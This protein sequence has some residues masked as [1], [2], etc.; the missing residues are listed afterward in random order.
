MDVRSYGIKVRC[1]LVSC[2]IRYFTLCTEVNPRKRM[3]GIHL[4][5]SNLISMMG[6]STL[7]ST[8]RN[9]SRR[10]QRHP[11]K[12]TLHPTI[13]LQHPPPHSKTIDSYSPMALAPSYPTIH[14]SIPPRPQIY[15]VQTC[16]ESIPAQQSSTQRDSGQSTFSSERMAG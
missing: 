14:T 3:N 13:P 5:N 8:S 6:R 16:Q 12:E 2:L 15:S 7:L 1:S 9:T 10:I 4:R 11:P